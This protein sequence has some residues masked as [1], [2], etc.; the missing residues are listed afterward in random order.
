MV[1]HDKPPKN[2]ISNA[3]ISA[4]WIKKI[5]LL[6]FNFNHVPVQLTT[7]GEIA[8]S[9]HIFRILFGRKILYGNNTHKSIWSESFSFYFWSLFISHR[10][11]ITLCVLIIV[12]QNQ[13]GALPS[14]HYKTPE[15]EKKCVQLNWSCMHKRDRHS[16]E[17]FVAMCVV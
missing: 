17:D 15:E 5:H 1:R 16:I 2:I 3:Q 8:F 13:C 10:L 12:H 7:T 4:Q 14:I 6:D 9:A 11:R